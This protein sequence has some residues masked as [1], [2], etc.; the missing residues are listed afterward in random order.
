MILPLIV[1]RSLRQHA[2]STLVTAGSIALASGLLL[3]V[4]MAKTQSEQAFVATTT[5]FDAVLGAR[6]S[7]LQ[8]VLNAIFNLEASPG[9]LSNADYLYIKHHPAV[10]EAIPIAVGDNLRGYRIV[11][12][13]NE[14]FQKVEY[15][16]GRHYELEPAPGPDGKDRARWF[17]ENAKEAVIGNFAA[18]KLGLKVGDTFHPFHGLV[19]DPN[20]QHVDLYTVVGILKPTNTP[21]DRVVWIPLHGLQTMSG[22]DPRY[23]TDVSAVLVQ[24]R[25][26]SAGFMLDLMYNRQG[27]RLTFA[28]PVGSIISDLFSRI[29]WFDRVLALVAYLVALVAAASVLASIYNSMSARRRDLAILRALGARRRTIFASVVAEAAVI[30]ILGAV[31]GFGFYFALFAIVAGIV[32]DQTG[33]VLDILAVDPVLWI[34]PLAMIALCALSGLVPALKAYRTPVAETLAP[35]S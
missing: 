4:W 7:K 35:L 20:A 12:T 25:A 15:A 2:L 31:A 28:Y 32:R 16:P 9:N 29:S 22:H 26:P 17:D 8:L 34:C 23:A 11:G 24:L 27:N 3:C 5:G 13:I 18:Y 14:L 21:A 10:K 6:G 33:V 19:F 1:Y 30:G